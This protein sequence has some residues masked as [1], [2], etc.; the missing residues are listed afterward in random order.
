MRANLSLELDLVK[1]YFTQYFN[2][3]IISVAN[4]REIQ[5]VESR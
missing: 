4:K 5:K 2:P 3:L 1:S